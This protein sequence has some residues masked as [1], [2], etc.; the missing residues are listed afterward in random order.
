MDS[1]RRIRHSSTLAKDLAKRPTE[2]CFL[3]EQQMAD[4]TDSMAMH[5]PRS[6]EFTTS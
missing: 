3:E 4:L 5:V 1:R 6:F 2:Q